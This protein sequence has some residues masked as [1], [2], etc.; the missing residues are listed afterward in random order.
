MKILRVTDK[1]T[2][3]ASDIA[4]DINPLNYEQD[5][6]I[7]N[8]VK[9]SAGKEI[10]DINKQTELMIKYSVKELRGATGY[11]GESFTISRDGSALTI[12]QVSDVVRILMKT[13][14]LGA[15]SQ[16]VFSASV[17]ELSGVKFL[18]ND[19]EVDLAKKK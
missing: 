2:I 15:I 14:L 6:E 17:P 3:K 13:K 16:T 8:C 18:V 1:V 5:I 11:D 10:N 19:K 7:S 9:I 4:I 12:D